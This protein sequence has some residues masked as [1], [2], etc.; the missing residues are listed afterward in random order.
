MKKETSREM[1]HALADN[2][3]DAEDVPHLLED[4]EASPELQAELC[5]IRRV[6]GLVKHAYP[7]EQSSRPGLSGGWFHTAGKVAAMLLLAVGSFSLGWYNSTINDGVSH[8]TASIQAEPDKS[9]IFIGYSDKERFQKTL[10]K[11]E[12]LLRNKTNPQAEV[13]VV[14]SA[15]GID[16]MRTNVS[17]HQRQIRKML[18]Q[19]DALHFVACNN[20]IYRYK[21]EGKPVNL[22]QD[23]EVAPSAVEFV[24]K[25]INKG[26]NYISI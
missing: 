3:L 6:K 17:P 4:I 2:Q 8:Q 20:T 25:R 12:E 21:Q 13:Y 16:L 5:D 18:E 15:G 1:L 23:V 7:L 26:W 24:A 14:A 11:A 9:I 10:V 19:H 22:I